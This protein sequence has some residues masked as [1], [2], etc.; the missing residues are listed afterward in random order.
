MQKIEFAAGNKLCLDLERSNQL[1]K[2]RGVGIAGGNHF[3]TRSLN[4]NENNSIKHF[5]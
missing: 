1:R 2:F 5:E 3:H 4:R